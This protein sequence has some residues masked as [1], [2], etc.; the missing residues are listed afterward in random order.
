MITEPCGIDDLFH[1]G[2]CKKASTFLAEYL[3]GYWPRTMH[4]GAILDAHC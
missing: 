4:I 3:T 2:H 1:L